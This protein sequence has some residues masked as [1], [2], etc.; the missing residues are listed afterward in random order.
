LPS[1]L[2]EVLIPRDLMD[3]GRIEP[4]KLVRCCGFA[5]SNGEARRLIEQGGVR[6]NDVVIADFAQATPVADGDVLRVGK[7][8]FAQLRVAR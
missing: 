2:P 7:R 4:V 5:G 1:E 3:D 8:R 6:V